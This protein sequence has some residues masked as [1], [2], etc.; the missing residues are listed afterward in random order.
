M[1]K[2][3]LISLFVIFIVNLN[4]RAQLEKGNWLVGGN[5][6]FASSKGT[7][8][9]ETYNGNSKTIDLNIS[10]NIG[11]FF[12]DKFA[13]GLK[14]GF[15]LNKGTFTSGTS[16]V[17]R[18]EIGPFARYYFLKPDKRVNIFSEVFYQHEFINFKPRKGN[19]N[20]FSINAGPVIYFNNSVGLEF[21]M[22]YYS[23]NEDISGVSKRTDNSFRMGI[24]LQIHLTN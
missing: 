14:P 17:K 4:A 18:F 13:A 15:S 1:M 24:G 11:Y 7:Y 21:T 9:Y 19:S 20:T 2:K 16:Y 23:R 22:G 12:T 8:A 5:A 10:P 6:S 3:A